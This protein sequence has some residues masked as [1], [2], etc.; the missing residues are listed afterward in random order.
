MGEEEDLFAGKESRLHVRLKPLP[1]NR[2]TQEEISSITSKRSDFEHNVNARGSTPSDYA[3]YVEFEI[4]VD[5]LRKKRVKRLGI[6]SV[7][8][9]GQR[10][11][12]FLF[13]RA[14]KK[15]PGDLGLW[16]QYLEYARRQRALKKLSQILTSTV[17]LHP[18][19]PELWMYAARFSLEENA[20]MME[21]R[22]YMQRGLRFCK[23]SRDLW[24]EYT[25]LELLYISKITARRQ[26]LGINQERPITEGSQDTDLNADIINLP[27]L[28]QDDM[29]SSEDPMTESTK[30][31]LLKLEQ[32]PALTGAVPIAIFDSAMKQFDHDS[33]LAKSFY[34]MINDFQISCRTKILGHIVQEML[35]SH[36][37]DPRTMACHVRIAVAGIQPDSPDFPS[38]LGTALS[39]LRQYMTQAV[40]DPRFVS[41]IAEWLK[42]LQQSVDLDPALAKVLDSTQ[43]LLEKA[44]GNLAAGTGPEGQ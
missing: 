2:T 15:F 12:F 6:K 1:D 24:L 10:R 40:G 29:N 25:K 18:R 22:S 41:E 32:S 30:A 4:N 23:S 26:I 13:D 33:V 28:T 7:S 43:S 34:D 38:A 31:A 37:S 3:K 5:T 19:R 42:G 9:T 11:I 21:A 39:R 16:M 14:T 44:P 20:D 35:L 36:P 17:R 8:H 27:Q